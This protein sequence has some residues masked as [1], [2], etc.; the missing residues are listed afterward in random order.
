MQR[1][2]QMGVA[3]L[4]MDILWLRTVSLEVQGGL[5]LAGWLLGAWWGR[6]RLAPAPPV[7][8]PPPPPGFVVDS[9]RV[10]CPEC[11]EWSTLLV[12][13][14]GAQQRVCEW[15]GESWIGRGV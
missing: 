13:R 15:C 5:I 10:P 1:A 8:A 7:V 4:V 12:Y 6:N 2:W 11:G 9:H 3:A 14:S